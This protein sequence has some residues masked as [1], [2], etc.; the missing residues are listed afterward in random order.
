M[1]DWRGVKIAQIAQQR[2]HG[3]CWLRMYKILNRDRLFQTSRVFAAS[4]QTKLTDIKMSAKDIAST[5][6][7]GKPCARPPRTPLVGRRLAAAPTP[8]LGPF[9][10]CTPPDVERGSGVECSVYGAD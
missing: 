1:Q 4:S 2:R 10:R 7:A 8:A 6:N 9:V 3:P 5:E